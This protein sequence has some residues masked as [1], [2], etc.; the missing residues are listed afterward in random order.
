MA[1]DATG[2]DANEPI[3]AERAVELLREATGDRYVLVRRLTGGE[4][5]AHEVRCV[6]RDE[7]F[8]LKWETRA[9]AAE[10]RREGVV[11]AN[12]LRTRAVWPVP[13]QRALQAD[14]CLL[15]LQEF[16][17]G[18]AA[19]VLTPSIV[20]DLLRLHD[21]RLGLGGGRSSGPWAERLIETLARG[22]HGYCD[23]AS[24]RRYD[25]RTSE[26]VREVEAFASTVVP[27]E[28]EGEDLVHW[29]LHPGNLLIAG[30]TVSA[31]I[32]TDFCAVGDAAF[33][34]VMLAVASAAYGCSPDVRR[35]LREAALDPLPAIR[36]KAY[37]GHLFVRFLD[38]PIRRGADSEVEFWLS[39]VERCRAEGYF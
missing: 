19:T 37:L 1:T 17:T 26:L 32:D 12:L 33:D 18:D 39:E 22:G 13:R 24:L 11:L 16:M 28:L 34:L 20:D 10:L 2:A 5:G 7:R 31:V 35:R 38:W 9:E 30:D 29:D 6:P 8:V 25:A 3:D 14:G 21:A 4:T 36:R 23:H 27:A 15:V